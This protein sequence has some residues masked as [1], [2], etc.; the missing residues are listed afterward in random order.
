MLYFAVLTPYNEIM[1]KGIAFA[2]LLFLIC[3]CE[4]SRPTESTPTGTPQPTG[5]A[6]PTANDSSLARNPSKA[7]F[8]VFILNPL[9]TC[10]AGND[11]ASGS[12]CYGDKCGDCVCERSDFDPPSPMVGISPEHINDPQYAGYAYRTCL[13][14]NLTSQEVEQI[15]RDM[16][17]VKEN[18]YEWSE[19]NLELDITYTELAVDFTG[20]VAPDYVIGPF[21]IDDELLNPYVGVD[22][23]FVYV[24]SG[25][26]D[27][28]QNLN[29]AYACGGSYGEMSIHGAGFASIQYNDIC[30]KVMIGGKFIYE[31]LIHEWYHNLDWALYYINRVPDAFQNTSPDWAAWKH[32]SWPECG[33]DLNPIYWFPSIDYCEWDPDWIDC[34]NVSSAGECRHA[35]EVMDQVSW[36]EHVIR[37]HYP[38]AI[39]FIGNYCRDGRQDFGETGVDMGGSCP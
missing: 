26:Y 31:P 2:V 7:K 23:D 27:R 36:Y 24:V 34:N 22:T 18:V 3:G 8:Q 32:A 19:G 35:G 25:V 38:G 4:F 13:E 17:L 29:L 33:K 21:E 37:A 5:T 15:K 10:L 20:F 30:N 16:E 28:Q 1:K 14:I 6:T 39:A 12:V 9:R 11:F